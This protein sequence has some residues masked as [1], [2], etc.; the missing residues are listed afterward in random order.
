LNKLLMTDEEK[1]EL[2]DIERVATSHPH[3][4]ALVISSLLGLLTDKEYYLK[5]S[6]HA[7]DIVDN[8]KRAYLG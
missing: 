5:S 8:M 2:Q 3:L 7:R 1:V 4:A 6:A